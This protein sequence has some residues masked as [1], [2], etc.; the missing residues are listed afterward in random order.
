VTRHVHDVVDPP[1]QPEVPFF[2]D[3][4]PVAGEVTTLEAAPVSLAVSLRVAVYSPQHGRPRPREGEVPAA[5]FHLPT[6]VVDDSAPIPGNGK[7][8]LPASRS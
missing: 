7:V 8:A 1:E 6:G 5:V 2:V 4:C 3:L